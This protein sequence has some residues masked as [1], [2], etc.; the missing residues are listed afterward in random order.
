V[1][2]EDDFDKE[3][4]KL[5]NALNRILIRSRE[6]QNFRKKL[7]EWNL[8]SDISLQMHIVDREDDDSPVQKDLKKI[9]QADLAFFKRN[10]IKWD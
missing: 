5:K 6:F 7:K 1:I 2:W 4:K 3:L 10:G 8:D 9:A